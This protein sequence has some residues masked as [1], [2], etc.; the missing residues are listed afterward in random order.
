[1]KGKLNMKRSWLVMAILVLFAGFMISGQTKVV[2]PGYESKTDTRFNDLIEILKTALDE[3]VPSFGPYTLEPSKSGMNEA[4]YLQDLKSNDEVNV[5]WTGTSEQKEQDYI[6]IRIPLRKG[7]LG[8]RVCLIA[9]DNQTGIDSIRTLAD[10]RK[11]TIG[12][13][14]GW[15]DVDIY[16][17]NGITVVTSEYEDLFKMVA[18]HRFDLYPRGIS[19]AFPEYDA[20]HE[21]IP[22]LG[23]EQHLLIYYPWPYYFFFNKSNGA[24]AKRVETGIRMMMKDGSFDAIFKKYNSV[25]IEKADLKDRRIIKVV[26][27]NLPKDTPL[28]DASLWFD[29]TKWEL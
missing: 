9:Q 15:G 5:A 8:F 29:P 6:P 27:P 7:I 13:G 23:I 2:Y 24:L 25:W 20:R 10:L 12:Q 22:N 3:T 1:M 21:A 14:T 16:R 17:A 18:G 26:N 4:R 28:D 19:E 11:A